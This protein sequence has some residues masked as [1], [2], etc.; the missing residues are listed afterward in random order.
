MKIEKLAF[1]LI[2]ASLIMTTSSM[3][4]A[5]I[6]YGATSLKDT[7]YQGDTI[8]IQITVLNN[9]TSVLEIKAVNVSIWRVERRYNRLRNIELVYNKTFPKNVKIDVGDLF[10]TL[11]EVK[12][13]F[14]PAQYNISV[15]IVA[16][17][18]AGGGGESVEYVV[19]SHLFWVKANFDIPILAWALI[20][21]VILVA[22]TVYIYR[23][24]KA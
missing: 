2:I 13:D 8:A 22:L 14:P 21:N 18:V 7:Y 3:Y 16:D 6:I 11:V 15:S 4:S 9:G 10:S 19:P 23:R 20:I 5:E 17:F 24:L 1:V 12:I